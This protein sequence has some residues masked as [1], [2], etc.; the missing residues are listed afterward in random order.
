MRLPAPRIS[1]RKNGSAN[2]FGSV[3]PFF[4]ATPTPTPTVT[5][6]DPVHS[7]TTLLNDLA[8]VTLNQVTL[9]GHPDSAFTLVTKATPLQA[10]VFGLLQIDPMSVVAMNKTS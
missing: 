6:G 4:V 7:V 2:P 10:K 8:T 5:D 3:A 9:P 1:G